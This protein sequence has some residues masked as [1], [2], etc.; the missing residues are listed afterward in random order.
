MLKANS[1]L[2]EGKKK[3]KEVYDASLRYLLFFFIPALLVPLMHA[4]AMIDLP[5]IP[6]LIINTVLLELFNLFLF[7]ISKSSVISLRITSIFAL[8]LGT[9]CGALNLARGNPLTP[10]D[11][12]SLKTGLS[13]AKGYAEKIQGPILLGFLFGTILWFVIRFKC[14]CHLKWKGKRRAV[15]IA[16][17]LAGLAISCGIL[18]KGDV[19]NEFPY[20]KATEYRYNGILSSFLMETKYLKLQQPDGYNK[21]E[22]EET[23]AQVTPY[24][25]KAA[26]EKPNIVIVL[27]E[28]FSDL[29]ISS[30]T[31]ANLP[32][33]IPYM[34]SILAG[35]VANTQSGYMDVS[36]LGGETADTEWEVMTGNSMLFVPSTSV[37]YAQYIHDNTDLSR[38]LPALLQA[39]GYEMTLLHPYLPG[40]YNRKYVYTKFGFDH[41]HFD[42][43]FDGDEKIRD[44][45]SDKAVFDKVEEQLN[46]SDSPQLVFAITMQN[47]GFYSNSTAASENAASYGSIFDL[48]D[49]KEYVKNADELNTYLT[50][51]NITD[52]SLKQ[53][54]SDI[55]ASDKDTIVVFFGDHQP[56]SSVTLEAGDV[57]EKDTAQFFKVPYFI[58]A[59]FAMKSGTNMNLSPNYLGIQALKCA[60]ITLNP[61]LTWVDQFREL[62]PSI[63][64]VQV[65]DADKTTVLESEADINTW[66]KLEEYQNLQY[67]NLTN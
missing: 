13:V 7:F 51:E 6:G 54:I 30:D 4:T 52:A 63:S 26:A 23:L 16:A 22:A 33:Y 55:D 20:D 14:N 28:A 48:K 58:H 34:K 42:D 57:D 41:I 44:F 9:T 50:L 53:F 8:A 15:G 35:N 64:A 29:T 65:T 11:F 56:P 18:I 2:S 37:P 32:D 21:K 5:E 46:K 25:G 17:L 27:D 1:N 12:F 60:G 19:I 10:S 39:N 62:F 24:E 45:Y 66:P 31:I 67:W 49:K 59:N 47:H 36:V 43:Y 38:S 61:Y 40:G 3:E